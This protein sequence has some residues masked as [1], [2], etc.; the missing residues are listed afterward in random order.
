MWTNAARSLVL[1]PVMVGYVS[2]SNVHPV[3]IRFH[4]WERR[5]GAIARRMMGFGDGD[6]CCAQFVSRV[7][8][9]AIPLGGLIDS[10]C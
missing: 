9:R 4:W 2:L 7:V 10:S 8:S 5:G 3:S 6:R 1:P